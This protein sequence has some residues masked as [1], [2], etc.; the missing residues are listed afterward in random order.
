MSSI[1]TL[2]LVEFLLD[3]DLSSIICQEAYRVSPRVKIID[4]RL[5]ADPIEFL[6]YFKAVEFGIQREA[7]EFLF[8]LIIEFEFL[9]WA[10]LP[11]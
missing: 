9:F 8:E 7:I 2:I 5:V 11:Y 1:S 10:S 6:Q 4:Y 3:S